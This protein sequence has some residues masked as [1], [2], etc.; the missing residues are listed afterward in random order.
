[1]REAGSRAADQREQNRSTGS[2]SVA[3][4][5]E[6]VEAI[7]LEMQQTIDGNAKRL[8]AL[9]AQLDHLSARSRP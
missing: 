6:R 5:L 4:R 2:S 8:T 1:M 9:Q 3:K 7:L